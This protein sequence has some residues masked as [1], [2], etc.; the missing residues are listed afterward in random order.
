MINL[1]ICCTAERG[2]I[3]QCGMQAK[4]LQ[5]VW[6]NRMRIQNRID[7]DDERRRV[8]AGAKNHSPLKYTQGTYTYVSNNNNYSTNMT[9]TVRTNLR[10]FSCSR[11]RDAAT[12]PA[13]D[14]QLG[15]LCCCTQSDCCSSLCNS[16]VGFDLNSRGDRFCSGD[17][18]VVLVLL[19]L[20]DG[21]VWRFI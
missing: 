21:C 18:V 7:Y 9:M 19:V 4:C 1:C 14:V 17:S 16:S 15:A 10:H 5:F 12:T 11:Q 6:N 8:I 2:Q 13:A 20:A 3:N